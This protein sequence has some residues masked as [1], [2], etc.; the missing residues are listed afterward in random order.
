MLR[1]AD[2]YHREGNFEN[3]YILYLKFLT[4][5]VEKII[6]HP[7][8]GTVSTCE[9]TQFSIRLKEVFPKTEALKKNLLARYLQDH[10]EFITEMVK[11][12]T[13]MLII[14]LMKF[15]I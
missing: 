1:M 15:E 3:A 2:V 11:F 9:K 14:T 13:V 10:Q 12:H 7:E 4:M 5:F 6:E 8:Y